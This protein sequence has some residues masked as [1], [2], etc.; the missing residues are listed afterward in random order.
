MKEK[1]RKK[2]VSR[3]DGDENNYHIQ[4]KSNQAK[5]S[6]RIADRGSRIADIP[7]EVIKNGLLIFI[8]ESTHKTYTILRI[9]RCFFFFLFYIYNIYLPILCRVMMIV[10]SLGQIFFSLCWCLFSFFFLARRHIVQI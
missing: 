5:K 8:G 1:R 10:H 4:L 6:F 3:M 2:A 7:S 9:H